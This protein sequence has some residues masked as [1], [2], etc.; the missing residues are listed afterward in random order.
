M[1][2]MLYSKKFTFNCD[3]CEAKK[4]KS[5]KKKA[6]LACR[7]LGVVF[8]Y[9]IK[10]IIPLSA[11]RSSPRPIS[12]IGRKNSTWYYFQ[13]SQLDT[14]LG[15]VLWVSVTWICW[16]HFFL[17]KNG[18]MQG[19][20]ISLSPTVPCWCF[21]WQGYPDGGLSHCLLMELVLLL[22]KYILGALAWHA[23]AA[24]H[25]NHLPRSFPV[26]HRWS[27]RKEARSIK[28]SLSFFMFRL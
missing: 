27:S 16:C 26:D 12:Y 6:A 20:H 14:K 1:D 23:G 19:Q 4:Q 8:W 7:H 13:A 10:S 21:A 17:E 15:N 22:L 11:Y 28:S 9:P 25:N 24:A 18:C 2:Y 3:R 5:H